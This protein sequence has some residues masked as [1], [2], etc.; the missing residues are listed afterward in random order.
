VKEP[1]H[2]FKHLKLPA[3]V[4]HRAPKVEVKDGKFVKSHD[5]REV[6]VTAID[7]HGAIV[8][9]KQCAR[10]YAPLEELYPAAMQPYFIP[11]TPTH[12]RWRIKNKYKKEP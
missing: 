4:L 12:L 10:Y 8:R 1:N 3:V 11:P 6:I 7:T 2:F 5:A 9:R